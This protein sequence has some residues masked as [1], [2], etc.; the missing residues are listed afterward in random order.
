MDLKKFKSPLLAFRFYAEKSTSPLQKALKADDFVMARYIIEHH[1][2]ALIQND[3]AYGSHFLMPR[4]NYK[5]KQVDTLNCLNAFLATSLKDQV[6]STVLSS[7]LSRAS[8]KHDLNMIKALLKFPQAI[9]I[10]KKELDYNGLYYVLP[11][12]D[13]RRL[14]ID[15]R[16]SPAHTKKGSSEI[17]AFFEEFDKKCQAVRQQSQGIS[18]GISKDNNQSITPPKQ[19]QSH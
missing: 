5:E 12:N 2:N 4:N 14:Q 17:V 13:P 16:S 9:H 10:D 15:S 7:L 19:P 8:A 18:S 3:I 11:E 1:Q 6:P